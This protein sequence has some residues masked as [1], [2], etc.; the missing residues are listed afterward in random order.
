MYSSGWLRGSSYSP[1]WSV[2]SRG[3]RRA[4]TSLSCM[5]RAR[6]RLLQLP[7]LQ[8]EFS[9]LI[10]QTVRF[11]RERTSHISFDRL[12]GRH[13]LI[14]RITTNMSAKRQKGT[15]GLQ[16]KR[17]QFD[18]SRTPHQYAP[19]GGLQGNDEGP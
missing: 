13:Q 4:P 10:P 7:S 19:Q 2:R 16:T 18:E 9:P 14:R 1:Q 17:R 12:I 3:V 5:R 15:R 6:L 8:N 11:I